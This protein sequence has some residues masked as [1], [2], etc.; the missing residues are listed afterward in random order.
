MCSE[1]VHRRTAPPQAGFTLV[2]MVIAIV[3]L[4]VGLVGV[5]SAFQLATRGSGDTAARKQ[6]AALAEELME[7]IQL[8]PYASAS[9]SAPAA[10]AR[11]T[12][13]DVADYAGYATTGKVCSLDGSP[14]TALN[15][16]SVAIR[17]SDATLAD[18]VPAKRIEVS[19]SN[20]SDSLTLTGWRTH[21]A[22]P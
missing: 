17:V 14:I 16:Y 20:A 13:N 2:E 7:E 4:G 22:A 10:C 12:Y 15:G 19:V 8:K 1:P 11:N 3:V 5:M 9:N 6:L 18:A 21:Y